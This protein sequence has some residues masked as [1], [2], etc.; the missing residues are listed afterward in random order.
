M[1]RPRRRG[2]V[3]DLYDQQRNSERP[4]GK[5]GQ[6]STPV[7]TAALAS[8]AS[9]VGNRAFTAMLARDGAGILSGGTV[10]PAVESAIAARRGSGDGLDTAAQSR[11]SEAFG[12]P[13]EDV[14][15]HT[16]P[17]AD[18]LARSVSARAFTTGSDVFFASG[19]YRP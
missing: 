6:D 3:V 8:L 14:R 1:L 13:F 19:E 5:P 7:P 16:D 18:E 15:V 17:A 11:F 9:L 10:H 12:D 2:V 4:A